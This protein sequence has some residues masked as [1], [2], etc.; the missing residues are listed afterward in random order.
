[1]RI[2]GTWHEMFGC[3]SRPT[4]H[5]SS[6][7]WT[8]APTRAFATCSRLWVSTTRRGIDCS[9]AAIHRPRRPHRTVPSS[10]PCRHR[11]RR[12]RRCRRRRTRPTWRRRRRTGPPTTRGAA[13]RWTRPSPCC[14]PSRSR[15]T[16]SSRATCCLP[17]LPR[18][19][20]RRSPCACTS[21]D[22]RRS[23]RCCPSSRSSRTFTPPPPSTSRWSGPPDS[24]C[25]QPPAST[26]ASGAAS[27]SRRTAGCTTSCP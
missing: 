15:C 19:T 16:T 6:R 8:T 4:R 10:S 2:A 1:M 22:P 26:A 13:W 7:A 21:L 3:T 24:R 12:R 5:G 23:S 27:R 20:P 18:A 9:A 11:R 14:S 25:R 17:S